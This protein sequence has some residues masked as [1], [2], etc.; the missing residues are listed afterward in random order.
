MVVVDIFYL[1]KA[2]KGNVLGIVLTQIRLGEGGTKCPP[3][4]RFCS[5]KTN[6]L[7]V[8]IR[9]NTSQVDDT[10]IELQMIIRERLFKVG[11][12]LCFYYRVEPIQVT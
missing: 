1:L 10:I 5:S 4:F 11:V 6:R 3:T 9:V 12:L 2:I 8:P 7:T